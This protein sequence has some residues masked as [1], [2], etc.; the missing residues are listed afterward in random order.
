MKPA[1]LFVHNAFP[2][3][4]GDLAKALMAAGVECAAIGEVHAPGLPG[5]PMVRYPI[6]RSSTPGILPLAA[7]PEAD[8]IRAA[9]AYHAAKRLKAEGF[10]PQVI[11]GHA[12]WGETLFLDEVFPDARL[13][14]YPE[15]F[16]RPH[17]FHVGFDP[18][19]KTPTD[20]ELLSTKALGATKALAMSDADA[21]VC[22]TRFQASTLPEVFQPLVRIIHEG[23]DVDAIRPGP[24]PRLQVPGGPAIEPGMPVVTHI[25]NNMEPARGLHIVAR[26]LPRLLAEVPGAQVLIF[27]HEA[28]WNYSGEPPAG[29]TWKEACLRGVDLDPGRVHFIGH[30]PHDQMLATLRASAAH[31]YYSYPFVLSWSI[32]EA[33]ASGCYV[34]GSDTAPLREVIRDGV[35]GR[36]LPF[37]DVDALSDALIAACRDPAASAPLR[38]EARRT[39]VEGYSTAKGRAEWFALLRELGLALPAA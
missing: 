8:T 34:I 38:A 26:A 29:M 28:P 30:V 14:I 37:F 33:M 17:G 31:V 24:A 1:V 27:G 18:E 10:A 4:F 36:L 5:L 21:I 13:V 23:I 39:V 3:Q 11:V 6:P 7:G 12:T 35:N 32:L 20:E 19:M 16:P 15:V 25:N 22:P 2:G 9:A